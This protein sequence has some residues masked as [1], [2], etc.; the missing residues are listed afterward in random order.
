MVT[1]KS[2]I[3]PDSQGM[4]T[5]QD[6]TFVRVLLPPGT[7]VLFPDMDAVPQLEN[8]LEHLSNAPR[9]HRMKIRETQRKLQ[10]IRNP[11]PLLNHRTFAYAFFDLIPDSDDPK[12]FFD[13]RSILQRMTWEQ[14]YCRPAALE[15]FFDDHNFLFEVSRHEAGPMFVRRRQGTELTNAPVTTEELLMALFN[16][17]PARKIDPMKGCRYD[18]LQRY[19][20]VRLRREIQRVGI[21]AVVAT[22]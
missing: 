5:R 11:L 1:Q 15:S 19:I 12:L 18:G 10:F 22:R 7:V 16:A 20:S 3:R 9:P 6:A 4:P 14:R 8:R 17:F 13:I 2:V 21:Q